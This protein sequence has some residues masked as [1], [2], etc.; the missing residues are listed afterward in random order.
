MLQI[1]DVSPELEQKIN[2]NNADFNIAGLMLEKYHN[3]PEVEIEAR[4][5]RNDIDLS[6]FKR[7]Q[8]YMDKMPSN[9]KSKKETKSLDIYVMTTNKVNPSDRLSNLRF[10]LEGSDIGEYCRT[11]TLP[12]NYQLLYKSPLYWNKKIQNISDVDTYDIYTINYNDKDRKSYMDLHDIRLSAKIEILFNKNNNKFELDNI[13]SPPSFLS[14]ALNKAND[15]WNFFKKQNFNGLFKTY[16]LK[17]RSRYHFSFDK[18]NDN[19][20]NVPDDFYIDITKVKSSKHRVYGYNGETIEIPVNNFIDSEIAEQNETY[21]IEF[22]I[23]KTS[24]ASLGLTIRNIIYPFIYRMLL[25]YAFKSPIQYVYSHSEEGLIRSLYRK[26]LNQVY[27]RILDY[28]ID[29]ISLLIDM[30]DNIKTIYRLKGSIDSNIENTIVKKL[31]D[32]HRKYKYDYFV[33]NIQLQNYNYYTR[34]ITSLKKDRINTS[35]RLITKL[36][37]YKNY[38]ENLK[39]NSLFANET[40]NIFISPQVVTIDMNNIRSDNLYSIVYNYTVTDK[41]DGQGMLLF[42][43]NS[44]DTWMNKLHLMDSNLR[45]LPVDISIKKVEGFYLF[46]GE[47]ITSLDRNKYAIFDT[48]FINGMSYL[49]A[50]LMIKDEEN[51]RLSKAHKFV[52]DELDSDENKMD[53]IVKKFILADNETSIWEAGREIWTSKYE[54]HLD[55]LIYT[56]ALEPVGY[57]IDNRDGD[58]RLAKTWNRNLKWKPDYENTIDCL[59]RFEKDIKA[60]YNAREV[61]IDKIENKAELSAGG[62]SIIR[63]YKVGN[64]F[65]GGSDEIHKTINDRSIYGAL[66]PKPFKPRIGNNIKNNKIYLPLIYDEMM[67]KWYISSKDNLVVEDD[68]IVELIYDKENENERYQYNWSVLRTRYD[69]TYLY[70]QGRK[71]QKELFTILQMCLKDSNP[72]VNAVIKVLKYIYVPDDRYKDPLKKFMVNRKYILDTYKTDEDIQVDIKIGNTMKVANSV[73]DS[74]HNPITEKNILYGEDIPDEDTYYNTGEEKVRSYSVTGVLQKFHNY[75]KSEILL[76]NAIEYCKIN[77]GYAHILD[78]TCGQ[79]GDIGKWNLYGATRCLGIDLYSNNINLAKRR[80]EKERQMNQQF[81]T[82]DFIVG[83]TSKRYKTDTKN[84]IELLYDREVYTSLMNNVYNRQPLNIISFMFSIHYFFENK[85]QFKN[86][87]DNINDHLAEGGLL[88]GTSFDGNRILDE[89]VNK[90]MKTLEID[91]NNI[92]LSDLVI[93]K[94]GRLILKISP[95]FIENNANSSWFKKVPPELPNDEGCIGLDI[96][97]FIYTIEKMV[98]EYLVN[99]KYLEK[100]L[101]KYNIVRLNKNEMV[102]MILPKIENES[103]SIGSFE[104]VYNL[105]NSMRDIDDIRL[106]KKIEYILDNLSEDEFSISKLNNYFMFIKKGKYK[107]EIKDIELENL[108]NKFN[109]YVDNIKTYKEGKNMVSYLENLKKIADLSISIK[110]SGTDSMKEYSKNIIVP[111]LKSLTAEYKVLVKK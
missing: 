77:M 92:K 105:I 72:D 20:D 107:K 39:N 93:Y 57:D 34:L 11:D 45:I 55:G 6:L 1:K 29:I 76:K 5:I 54:Y 84:A 88:I 66:K 90:F 43:F 13:V 53:I 8:E 4:I 35:D 22:E 26:E 67:G 37:E 106:K 86:M 71:G 70:K 40:K 44:G 9:I 65:N 18:N 17:H 97:V 60:R 80:Y 108:Q 91:E 63:Q 68:T 79:G 2:N 89:F 85:E 74:I 31:N 78:M 56:P 100:E 104:D 23:I 110:Q 58:L 42:C 73:W 75:V 19:N 41:A 102:G 69:K 27:N 94:D 83:D 81:V 52:N 30:A 21:E 12:K 95:N 47:Y 33:N 61:L 7:I 15:K 109:E 48:Y 3:F 103:V 16:R 28:K 98:K 24:Q 10:T 51:T 62:Q 99:Y 82:I 25:P 14:D 38:Y 50:P 46:N 59:I 111:K 36:S 101:G 64:I 49:N 96:D 87:I 32:I